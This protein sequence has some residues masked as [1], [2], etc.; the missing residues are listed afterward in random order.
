MVGIR[1]VVANTSPVNRQ[2]DDRF[3]VRNSEEYNG[4]NGKCERAVEAVGEAAA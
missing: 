4:G 1:T 2:S 3:H